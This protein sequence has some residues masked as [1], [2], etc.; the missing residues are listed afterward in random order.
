MDA[1]IVLYIYMRVPG[2]Q[3]GETNALSAHSGWI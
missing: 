2:I 1:E 3:R